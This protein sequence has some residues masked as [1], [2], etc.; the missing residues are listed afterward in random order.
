MTGF[1][2]N[3]FKELIALLS[4]HKIPCRTLRARQLPA[5]PPL[6][7]LIVLLEVL[8]RHTNVM[9]AHK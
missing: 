6:Y 5:M 7:E 1:L 3:A 9:F 8:I 4:D 2:E